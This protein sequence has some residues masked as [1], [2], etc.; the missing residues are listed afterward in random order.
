M[1][2]WVWKHAV[3]QIQGYFLSRS[4]ESWGIALYRLTIEIDAP[5][6]N[7][8]SYNTRRTYFVGYIIL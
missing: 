6:L 5:L 4:F 8:M 2:P 7:Y 1:K 3:F